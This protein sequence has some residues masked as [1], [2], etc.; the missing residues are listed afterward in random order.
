MMAKKALTFEESLAQLEQIVAQMEGGETTLQELMQNYAQGVKLS[1]QCLQDLA[2][3]EQAM[4]IMVTGE[5]K[6]ITEEHLA[7]E[8]S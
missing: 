1:Q 4:D 2:R 6:D 3:A 7:I 8:E 5:G